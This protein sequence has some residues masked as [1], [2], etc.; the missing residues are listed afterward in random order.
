MRITNKHIEDLYNEGVR[1]SNLKAAI[2]R[3]RKNEREAFTRNIDRVAARLR[4][5]QRVAEHDTYVRVEKLRAKSHNL[6]FKKYSEWQDKAD[7]ICRRFVSGYSMG[8]TVSIFLAGK[9]FY[10]LDNTETYSGKYK[11]R[12]NHGKLRIHLTKVDF[13]RLEWNF[14]SMKWELE[15]GGKKY[16]LRQ[17]KGYNQSPKLVEI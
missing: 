4:K 7:S 13:Q 17:E 2:S 10:K 11:G 6:S 12:E 15:K 5:I 8:E 16:V 14:D 9:L 1:A 3:M